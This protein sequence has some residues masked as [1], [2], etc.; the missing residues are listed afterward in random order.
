MILRAAKWGGVS[1]RKKGEE[2]EKAVTKRCLGKRKGERA[3][4]N[5]FSDPA[6]STPFR[7]RI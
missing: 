1:E 5:S 3:R 2:E 6:E 4:G 7:L